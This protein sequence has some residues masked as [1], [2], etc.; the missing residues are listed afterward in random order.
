MQ[1]AYVLSESIIRFL[2]GGVVVSLFSVL[3]DLFRPKSF[4]GL[5]DAAPSVALATLALAVIKE[6]AIYAGIESRSMIAGAAALLVY[7]QLTS[8]LLMRGRL[9][10]LAASLIAL[11]LW[12]AAAFL[13]WAMF[14]R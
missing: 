6:D 7:S 14:L 12:F 3:G 1:A 5:F 10:S 4:A 8:W 11:P 13:L 2:I 9:S